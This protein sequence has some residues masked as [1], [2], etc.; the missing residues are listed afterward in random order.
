MCSSHIYKNSWR[1]MILALSTGGRLGRKWD[2]EKR[3]V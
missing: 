2:P 1:D 3:N